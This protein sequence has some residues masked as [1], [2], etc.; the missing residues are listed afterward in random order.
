MTKLW[1]IRLECYLKSD[2]AGLI[3]GR[4]YLTYWFKKTKQLTFAENLAW[5]ELQT[6]STDNVF[7]NFSWYFRSW[8]ASL[9]CGNGESGQEHNTS[10]AL[11]PC[12]ISLTVSLVK[13]TISLNSLHPKSDLQILLCLKPEDFTL[14]V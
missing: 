11:F 3:F 2:K 8:A 12:L 10:F 9:L 7:F 5:G 14:S 4:I 13:K 6:S 1:S